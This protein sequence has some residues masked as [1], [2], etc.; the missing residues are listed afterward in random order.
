M[1]LQPT[2]TRLVWRRMKSPV[3][4][5]SSCTLSNVLGLKFQ[6]KAS[7]VL[8]SAKRA[9]RM[10]RATARSRR[11]SASA[12]NSRSR[13]LRCEKLSFSARVRSSSRAAASTG[14]RSVAKWLRQRSRKGI[15]WCVVFAFVGFIIFR[16]FLQQRLV[17]GRGTRGQRVLTQN[18]VQLVSR[19]D[20]Q[21]FHGRAWF[22]LRRQNALHRG[23][24]ESA[25]AH[26]SLQRTR[27]ILAAVNRQQAE[28]AR[29]LVLSIAPGAQQFIEEA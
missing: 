8:F 22:G 12:P 19:I 5:S 17:L 14:I 3:A 15:V 20:G 29:S 10:R 18:L 4:S 25:I 1:P 7:R 13:K 6:S 27:Q 16:R 21:R 23:P 2:M 28:H 11:A 9:S 26:G 24:G